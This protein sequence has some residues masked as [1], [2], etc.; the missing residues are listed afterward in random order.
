[1]SAS[2]PV[3]ACVRACLRQ[4]ADEGVSG[5]TQDFVTARGLLVRHART[6]ARSLPTPLS[7]TIRSSADAM[8]RLM[9]SWKEVTELAGHTARVTELLDT[10]QARSGA[11]WLCARALASTAVGSLAPS[12]RQDVSGGVYV[13]NVPPEAQA[14]LARRGEV[15]LLLDLRAAL[16]FTTT[17]RSQVIESDDGVI[18]VNRVPVVT[19]NGDILVKELSFKITPGAHEQPAGWS[20]ARWRKQQS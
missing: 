12:G 1:M 14:T 4:A 17:N 6:R 19:P 3:R 9:S 20:A 11:P 18:E 8:E 16:C 13:K 15:L 2:P 7:P 10:F 5:R